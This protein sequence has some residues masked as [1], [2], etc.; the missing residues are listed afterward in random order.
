MASAVSMR[1]VDLPLGT[2][3]LPLPADSA[4]LVRQPDGAWAIM[5][6]GDHL[7]TVKDRERMFFAIE[8]V[9]APLGLTTTYRVR[10]HQC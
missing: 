3:S 9:L 10:V 4:A 6:V 8:D 5:Y 1:L 2:A 7:S